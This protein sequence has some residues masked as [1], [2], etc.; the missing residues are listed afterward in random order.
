MQVQDLSRKLVKWVHPW[1]YL[2]TILWPDIVQKLKYYKS[3][4]HY[5]SV[6]RRDQGLGSYGF[7]VK[8]S[9]GDL[10]YAKARGIVN[11]TNK[12]AEELEEIIIEIDSLSLLKMIRE[13]WASRNSGYHKEQTTT[14]KF[15]YLSYII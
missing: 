5:H 9:Q 15:T 4:F 11:A 13:Q 10:I 1:I 7:Y 2:E 3:K 6:V 14:I 8:N 12:Q